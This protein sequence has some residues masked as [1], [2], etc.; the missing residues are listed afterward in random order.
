[1]VLMMMN[2]TFVNDDHDLFQIACE[3]FSEHFLCLGIFGKAK[4][5]T[6]RIRTFAYAI[7]KKVAT[8]VF[9]FV[10]EREVSSNDT[11]THDAAIERYGSTLNNNIV[12]VMILGAFL[13]YRFTSAYSSHV[14]EENFFLSMKPRNL[15]VDMQT[16]SCPENTAY[17]QKQHILF[18]LRV[19][20]Q[21]QF[22]LHVQHQYGQL[23]RSWF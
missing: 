21:I 8:W 15:D 7:Q 6:V 18:L 9:W 20:R 17:C 14:Y 3:S 5:R 19:E 10:L 1:M 2:T 23:N 13:N 12:T 4:Q 11:R 22:H 16:L